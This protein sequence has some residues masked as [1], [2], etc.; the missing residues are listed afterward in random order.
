LHCIYRDRLLT[1]I[2]DKYL[3]ATRRPRYIGPR[4][5]GPRYIG[6]RYIGPRYIGPRYIGPRYNGV[7]V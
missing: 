2:L 5:I 4:Y 3:G 1:F 6:P 7:A